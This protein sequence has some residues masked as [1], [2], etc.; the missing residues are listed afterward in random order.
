VEG[1][2]AGSFHAWQKH[3][4]VLATAEEA[5]M[6]TVFLEYWTPPIKAKV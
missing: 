5:H 6:E 4:V 3:L 1:D 2:A